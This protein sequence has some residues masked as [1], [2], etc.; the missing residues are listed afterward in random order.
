MSEIDVGL[1]VNGEQV[2]ARCQPHD[3]LLALLRYRLGLTGTKE[4]CGEG[5]CGACT[6][7]MDGEAVDSCLVLAAQ[8]EGRQVTT[9]EG[10]GRG[11]PDGLHPVQKAFMETGAVQCG[12]CIP[13]IIMSAADA[14]TR[15]SDAAREEVR[16][17]VAGNLC[18]CTGYTK[19]FDAIELARDRVARGEVRPEA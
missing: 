12:F 16:R 13:G 9:I 5:E 18:R 19:I 15:R 11:W 1:E 2:R 6:V 4:G 10:L 3:T 14:I 7:F 17:L 8:C